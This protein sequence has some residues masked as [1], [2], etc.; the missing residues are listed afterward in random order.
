METRLMTMRCTR[1]RDSARDVNTPREGF[2]LIETMVAVVLLVGV[3]LT[4]GMGTTVMSKQVSDSSGRSRGQALADMQ[5]G[6]ARAWPTYATLSA[7]SAAS[8]NVA[9]GGLTPVTGVVVDTSGGRS[10][11]RVTVTVTGGATSGLRT[12]IVRSIS[13]A[14][15]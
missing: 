7:L 13:I 4:M 9:V 2:T 15:P 3:V 10:L 12:P 8:F 1:R 5:I 6:R 11:T 14:A